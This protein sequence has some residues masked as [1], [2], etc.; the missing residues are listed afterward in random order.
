VRNRFLRE[1]HKAGVG[2]HTLPDDML[3]AKAWVIDDHWAVIGSANI[4]L[5]SLQL[6]FELMTLLHAQADVVAVQTWVDTQLARTQPWQAPPRNRLRE[7]IE[8][9]LMLISFQL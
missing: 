6:N 2:I 8:G 4:D 9:L 7:T 3:H 1:L 5:R